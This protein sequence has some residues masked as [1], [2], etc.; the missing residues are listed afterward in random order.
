MSTKVV[1]CLVQEELHPL[2]R[3]WKSIPLV[4]WSK[5]NQQ[6]ELERTLFQLTNK[7]DSIWH[8]SCLSLSGMSS[9]RA[10]QF[11]TFYVE[12]VS[13]KFCSS[14]HLCHSVVEHP[15]FLKHWSEC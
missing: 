2:P 10:N 5:N 7:V 3:D 6:L 1:V 15:E 4:C 13:V 11:F 8:N 9:L 14:W 12:H